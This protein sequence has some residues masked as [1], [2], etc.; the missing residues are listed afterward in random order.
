VLRPHDLD[1][2]QGMAVVSS[3]RGWWPAVLGAAAPAGTPVE[4][5]SR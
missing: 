3:L 2:A 1:G 4:V 5:G